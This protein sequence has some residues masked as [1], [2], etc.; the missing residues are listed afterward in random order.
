MR[1]TKKIT[2]IVLAVMMVVSMMSVMAVT[3]NAAVGE[4]VPEED[5]LTFTALQDDSSVMMIVQSGSDFKYNKNGDGWHDYNP[6][7]YKRIYLNKGEY[8]RFRGSDFVSY[9]SGGS[10][11]IGGKV[12]A[13]GN[14]MSLRL[15]SESRSQG[16]TEACFHMMFERCYDLITAPELPETTLAEYCYEGMFNKCTNLTKAPKLPATT[17]TRGCYSDMFNGCTSLTAAPALPATSLAYGCYHSMFEGCTS[18][19]EL[20]ELPATSLAEACYYGMFDGCSSIRISDEAGTFSGIKYSEAY[21]IPTEGTATNASYALN[22]MFA[23]TGGRF[24]GTPSLNTTYYIGKPVYTVKWKNGDNVIEEDTGVE[25]GA[26][27]T[28]NGTTPEK[29]EDETNTYTF[30][31]W[32]DG[33]TTYGLSDTL[34]NVTADVTYTAQFTAVPKPKKLTLNVGENGKVVMDNGTFGNATDASNISEV[35]APIDVADETKVSIVEG[36]TANL[37]EGGSINIATGGEVSFYPSADNT[38]VITATPDVG[39]VFEGWYNGDT[40]YS[41]D[42]ALSYQNISEN[43]TLTAK[44]EAAPHTHDFTYSVEGATITATCTADG[45]TLDDGTEQHNHAVTL[46]LVAPTLTT[47]GQTGEGISKNATLDGLD[48]F[49]AATG[50][51]V[52]ATDIKYYGIKEFEIDGHTYIRV[53]DELDGAPTAAGS[54][55]AGITLNNVKTVSSAQHY[56]SAYL[57]YSIAK[58][59]INPTVT[60]EGW[61]YGDEANTPVVTGNTGNGDVT[62]LYKVKGDPELAYSEYV[63]TDAGEYTVKALVAATANYNGGEATADFTIAKADINPTVTLDGWAY[64]ETANTPSVTGNSGNGD[65]TYTYAV[66]GS[67]EFSDTVPTDANDYTVKASIAATTNYKSATATADFTIAKADINPTVTLEGWTYGETANT[68]SVDGNTGNGEVTYTYAAK[69]SDEFSDKVPTSADDYTVKAS[70]AATTNYKSA[71]ATADFTIAKADITPT[72]TLEGW[73]YGAEAKTPVVTGNSGDGHVTYTYAVKGTEN[74]SSDVPADANEYTVKASIAATTNYNAAIATADFTIAKADINPTVTLEGWT[75]G[76]EAKTPVVDGNTGNGE[77]T[78]T[79]AVK[80]SDEFSDTVPTDAND[81]TVKAEIAAAGNYANAVATADFTIAKADINP[82][83]TLEGWAYGAEAKTPVVTGNSGDGNVTYT[84]AVKGSDEFSD[85]VPTNAGDYTVKASVAATTNYNAATATADFTIAKADIN[86]TVTLEGWTYGETANT[87]SVDGNTGEG[88]VTY[89]YKVKGETDMSCTENVPTNAGEYTVK[90]LVGATANY[91]G[92]E[93]TVDFTIAKADINPTVTLEGWTYGEEAKTPVVTGNSGDGHVTYTYAVK[94]SDEFGSDVPTNAGEYTVKASVA[95]TT[96]YNAAI[97]TADFTIAKADINPTV[98]LEGWTYGDEANTPVVNGNSGDGEVTYAYKEKDASDMSS[99]EEAPTDAGEYTVKALIAE[100]DNYN[101][102]EATADFTI[103]K[104]D[105]NPTV[106][107]EGWAYGEEAKTPVVTGN[108]GNGD[109]TY[110]YKEKDASDMSSTEEAPTDAG[111]YTVKALIAETD[112][113]NAGEAT[114]DFTIA[115]ADITP[116]VTLEGWTYGDEAN[117]P[118]VTGNSGNGEVTYAYKEKDAS[119]M[120]STEEAPTDAGEYTVKALIAETD[121]YNAGEATADFT[122]AKADINPTVT[123]EGW[124]YGEEANKPVVDGNTDN[125]EVTF[126]YKIKDASDMSSTDEAPT[127]AGEYTVK[128]II[129]ETD[130]YNGGEATADFTIAKAD[131][132]VTAKKQTVKFGNAIAQDKYTVKGLVD[133]DKIKVTLNANVAANT[134]K[135]VVDAGSNYK[136]TTVDSILYVKDMPIANALP[137]GKKIVVNY[138]KVKNA[139]GYKIYAGYCGSKNFK[140]VKT[141]KGNTKTSATLTKINGK[142]IN[143]KGKVLVYVVAYKN[144]NGKEVNIVRGSTLHIACSK[145]K[146]TNAKSVKVAKKAV[147]LKKGKTSKIKATVTLVKKDAKQIKHVPALRYA[148]SDKKIAKVSSKGKITAVSKGTA[149]I[150]V[151]TNNGKR[152]KVKVTVK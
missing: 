83:V 106:T 91:N 45:C 128:A 127:D 84:Y 8:V 129:A 9:Y 105:I 125:G 13:S 82:T 18:L 65:V 44:F 1:M 93:A 19:T 75:Y 89:L 66:K 10:F 113:Y 39:Y 34:P 102:G 56:I 142:A 61:T 120:S 134:I 114:A 104:A 47:Y 97:A 2:S 43:I 126:A 87:P 52:A 103:A 69:G 144:V 62:Y 63:P 109:V 100:T 57:F 122:I 123:I 92:G 107:L 12:A 150:Y 15:D 32:S 68:P 143:V 6:D 88:N 139:D 23:S 118:V 133:G 135:P 59:D 96:N 60:L 112:N 131:M 50:K 94:G 31:G 7:D 67:D 22:S 20:P 81:Y 30:S 46:T 117:T 111:D 136:V 152:A 149:T 72:V 77:V 37:V 53:G 48:A 124:T 78:Y 85:T 138:D 28:F 98:T 42:A 148:S 64:D 79:Y 14:I 137:K 73:A 16:L 3:A 35:P 38:G 145:N 26:T 121:N 4:V 25:S 27:P 70:V 108:S 99:T 51:N 40:L 55:Y 41:S 110:A 95:A 21:R 90:A 119:D 17:L 86:P 49:N 71:T 33:N 115:K 5:Y 36:H 116:T 76:E 80:G 151:Y 140:V 24:K 11:S 141:V 147:T 132:T 74:F 130:N 58:A 54:Y 29:A 146:M 101:A